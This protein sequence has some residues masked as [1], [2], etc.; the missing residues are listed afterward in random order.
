M[1]G[2]IKITTV[3][4]GTIIGA[5]FISGQEIYSFFNKYGETGKIGILVSIGLIALVIYKTYKIIYE[6]NIKNYQELLE[7]TIPGKH[8]IIVE[9]IKNII[10]IFL[11]ISFLI[12]CSA[13][14]TYCNET[15]G[16]PKLIG[17]AIISA[18]S[19]IILINDV[20]AIIETNEILM[21]IIII[22]IIFMGILTIK[23]IETIT[24]LEFAC[25]PIIKGLLYANYNSIVLIPMLLPLKEQIKT[26][27][28]IKQVSA[29]SFIIMLSLTILIYKM[30]ENVYTSNLEMPM[31]S[32]AGQI[33]WQFLIIYGIM[34]GI[35][36]FTSSISAGY[37]LICNTTKEKKKL[38][39]LILCL[40]AIPM[41]TISFSTLVNLM[42]PIF[43]ILGTLQIIF[44]LKTW[45]KT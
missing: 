15:Y 37:S 4:I 2:V 35:A 36:I 14:S 18:L 27:K 16:M 7:A 31:L 38:L 6:K 28:Q 43:G 34:T 44:L 23:N 19:Y 13:F 30:Q 20:K 22:F 9:T 11:I 42:Y 21:P 10:N 29:I 33:S 25:K 40:I 32:V 1:Q 8:K 45:K 5:G 39:A 26:K 17:G 3:I 41:S 24:N 12:M